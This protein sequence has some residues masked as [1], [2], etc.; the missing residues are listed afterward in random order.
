MIYRKGKNKV[1]LLLEVDDDRIEDEGDGG[2][3]QFTRYQSIVFKHEF[4]CIKVQPRINGDIIVGPKS[5][6]SGMLDMSHLDEDIADTDVRSNTNFY[7]LILKEAIICTA[8]YC[9]GDIAKIADVLNRA[10]YTQV[11]GNEWTVANLRTAMSNLD[12]R[13]KDLQLV[14][15]DELIG[16][17]ANEIANVDDKIRN[18]VGYEPRPGI[19]M[20]AAGHT[21]R[22]EEPTTGK[23]FIG[24]GDDGEPMYE[25]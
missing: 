3:E 9:R 4:A 24:I 14:P 18:V 7:T 10:G 13:L 11:R 17:V 5:I 12:I 20:Q 21:S 15:D 2:I 23:K 19:V 1:Y 6:L 22:Q 8:K 25:D 16:S